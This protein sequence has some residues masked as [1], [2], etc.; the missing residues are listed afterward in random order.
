MHHGVQI[1]DNALVA[2]AQ[3]SKRYILQRFLP[4]KAIDLVD[5]ACAN[6]RVQLDSRPEQIDVLER[7]KLQLEI[8]LSALKRE[9]DGAS[10]KRKLKV[11]KIC[12]ILKNR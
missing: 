6:I 4:D 10:K 7:Q 11:K 12:K 5:E 8:E 9:K 1:A 3:L 2:A